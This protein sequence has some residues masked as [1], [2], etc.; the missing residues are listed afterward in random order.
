LETPDALGIKSWP[1]HLRPAAQ[2]ASKVTGVKVALKKTRPLEIHYYEWSVSRWR[3]SLTFKQLDI[4]GKAIYRE[5][6]DQCYDQGSIPKDPVLQA[7]VAG[8]SLEQVEAVWPIIKRHFVAHRSD[9]EKLTHPQADLARRNTLNYIKKQRSNRGGKLRGLKVNR[10]NNIQDGGRDI[11]EPIETNIP[12]SNRSEANRSEANTPSPSD[13]WDANFAEDVSRKGMEIVREDL[14]FQE[15]VGMFLAAGVAVSETDMLRAAREWVNYPADE[16]ARI[17]ADVRQK[18]ADGFWSEARYTPNPKNY[19]ADR[20]WTRKSM[21]R[22]IP[23]VKPKSKAQ[24][25]QD[26]AARRFMGGE[27]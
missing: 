14:L 11:G 12:I 25:A 17:V 16:H 4:T 22:A 8:C 7:L 5:L 10:S 20:P 6:L 15:F 24:E 1:G 13:A 27:R 18:L 19:M 26:E 23:I 9:G 2:S 3:G 21:P